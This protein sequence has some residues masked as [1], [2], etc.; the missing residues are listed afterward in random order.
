MHQTK[1]GF[2]IGAMIG[3][4]WPLLSLFV[5]LPLLEKFSLAGM[6]VLLKLLFTILFGSTLIFCGPESC[7]GSDFLIGGVVI[8]VFLHIIFLGLIGAIIGR[9]IRKKEPQI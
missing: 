8:I 2:I 5:F 6:N 1:K 3:L 4:V 7:S 9:F